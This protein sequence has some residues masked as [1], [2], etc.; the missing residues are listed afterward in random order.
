[1]DIQLTS[2][3]YL[4]EELAWRRV[5][6]APP[7]LS[8]PT[9]E[10]KQ[11]PAGGASTLAV[12]PQQQKTN[13]KVADCTQSEQQT[14]KSIGEPG[15]SSVQSVLLVATPPRVIVH[16]SSCLGRIVPCVASASSSHPPCML[17]DPSSCMEASPL[18]PSCSCVQGNVDNV[19]TKLKLS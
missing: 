6:N 11:R 12:P 16:S 8:T 17:V 18:S 15:S 14:Q 19:S 13:K 2:V 10:P 5:S 9:Q 4:I 7:P 1:M 3:Q